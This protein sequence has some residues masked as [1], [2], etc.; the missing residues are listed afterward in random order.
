MTTSSSIC[1]FREAEILLKLR[2]GSSPSCTSPVVGD[3]RGRIFLG[4]EGVLLPCGSSFGVDASP[5][6]Q[7]VFFLLDTTCFHSP[8]RGRSTGVSEAVT[9]VLG[10]CGIAL[11]DS[12]DVDGEAHL[13]VLRESSILGGVGTAILIAPSS[14]TPSVSCF[15]FS[16]G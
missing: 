2:L 4:G 14:V 10:P 1:T 6:L 16:V 13:A 15:F 9:G 5:G 3:S 8:S 7:L 11:F 12:M